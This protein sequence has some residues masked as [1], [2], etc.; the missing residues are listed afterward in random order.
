MGPYPKKEAVDP[1]LINA[2][3]ETVRGSVHYF[4]NITVQPSTDSDN[5]D[6][7]NSDYFCWEWKW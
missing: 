5:S 4:F 7:D 2:G 3:K 1:D 6:D